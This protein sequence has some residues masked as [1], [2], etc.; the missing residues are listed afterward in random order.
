MRI[1]LE[2]NGFSVIEAE[3]GYEAVEKAVRERPDLV[4]MDLAMPVL[5][6]LNSTRAI[7][8]H[9]ELA[10]LPIVALTAY[11][12]FYDS[13]AR[14]AGCTDVLQKPIDFSRLK[15]LVQQYLS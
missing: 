9:E 7:R 5:D 2:H 15:P 14:D 4:L 8:Q 11:G 3:D 13:R 6:G 10:D 12:D 1:L